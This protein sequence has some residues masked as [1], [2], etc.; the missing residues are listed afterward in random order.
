M[1]LDGE[2][3]VEVVPVGKDII[4]GDFVV[5]V[6]GDETMETIKFKHPKRIAR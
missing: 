4:R 2:K 5:E 3:L 6:E 1:T